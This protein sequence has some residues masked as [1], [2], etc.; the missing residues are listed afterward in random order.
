MNILICI[1]FSYFI[2]MKQ[3]KFDILIFFKGWHM[4]NKNIYQIWN[5]LKKN[6]FN[7]HYLITMQTTFLQNK[8]HHMIYN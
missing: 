8:N 7:F 6:T 5:H 2:Q 3:M 1:F 4:F